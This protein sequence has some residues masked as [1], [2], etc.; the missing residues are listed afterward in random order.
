MSTFN[1][2]LIH[3]YF[4]FR[5]YS[6]QLSISALFMS[7]CNFNHISFQLVFTKSLYLF[8]KNSYVHST[9]L[10][11]VYSYFLT[12]TTNVSFFWSTILPS[13]EVKKV[14]NPATRIPLRAQQKSKIKH[15]PATP[16]L[17]IL[18]FLPVHGRME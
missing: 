9:K 4:Q 17:H 13:E 15:D 2:Y 7:T 11:C 6:C 16:L 5:P 1:F 18:H 14:K 10:L 3:V 12:L 8:Y